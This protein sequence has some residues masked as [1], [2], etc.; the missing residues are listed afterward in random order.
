MDHLVKLLLEVG[1]AVLAGWAANKVVK[2]VTGR[3]IPQHLS[4]W[5]NKVNYEISQWIKNH[6]H[7][8]ITRVVVAVFTPIDRLMSASVK[9][10]V[11]LS[12]NAE[13]SSGEQKI[14]ERE[15]S[16]EDALKMFPEFANQTKVPISL[17]N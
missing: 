8:K 12:F 2:E 10:M 13:T 6:Q 11:K 5:W 7:L 16:D 1:G 17:T 9:R 3:S 14:T 4:D 15:L